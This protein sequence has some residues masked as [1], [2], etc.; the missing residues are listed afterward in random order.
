MRFVAR[1]QSHFSIQRIEHNRSLWL[2][3][4]VLEE[5]D[6]NTRDAGLCARTLILAANAAC[7]SR[8]LQR[9]SPKLAVEQLGN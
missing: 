9:P 6:P 1:R 2:Y 3:D 7:G 8:G 4:F 5:T